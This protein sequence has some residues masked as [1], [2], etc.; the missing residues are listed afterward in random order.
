[1]TKG[2]LHAGQ[3]AR[4]GWRLSAAGSAMLG[5]GRAYVAG[6]TSRKLRGDRQRRGRAGAGAEFADR[7]DRRGQIDSGGCA[8]A[9]AWGEGIERCG[10][11][12][13]RKGHRLLCLR[14]HGRGRADSGDARHR[15]RR[16]RD[17]VAPGDR[18]LGQGPRL[19][20]QSAGHG[21]SV[22]AAGTGARADSRAI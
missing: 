4:P 18:N 22:E 20:E 8:G 19:C 11:S 14:S 12:R 10:A 16:W 21:R 15:F 3:R 1:M 9:S 5:H 13:G 6:V 7:G 2:L 17:S